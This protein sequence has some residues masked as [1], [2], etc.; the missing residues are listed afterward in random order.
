MRPGTKKTATT[1]SPLVR[2]LFEAV[3]ASGLSYADIHALSGVHPVTMSYW[4]HGK[5]APRWVDFEHVAQV[6]GFRIELVPLEENN[7]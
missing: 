2:Q 7:A 1:A 5:N 6:L 3:D 4:K